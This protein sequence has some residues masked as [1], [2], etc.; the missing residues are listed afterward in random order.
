MVLRDS[1]IK[2]HVLDE[3]KR[4]IPLRIVSA[5]H[6]FQP[7]HVNKPLLKCLEDLKCDSKAILDK[8]FSNMARLSLQDLNSL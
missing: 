3:K 4:S 6:D 7:A 5:T 2:F 8:H 1:L